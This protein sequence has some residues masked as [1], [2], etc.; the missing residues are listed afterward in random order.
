MGL[1]LKI[2]MN[3]VYILFN[4]ATQSYK[5]ENFVQLIIAFFFSPLIIITSILIDF[6]TIPGILLKDSRDFERKY[7]LNSDRFNDYQIDMFIDLFYGQGWVK[8]KGKS[9]TMNELMVMHRSVFDIVNNMHDLMCRGSK[10]YR[11]ALQN[12]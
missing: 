6:I 8:W 3:S 4:R 11:Q 12:V 10:D 9:M 2:M 7:Q 1:Y 5:G